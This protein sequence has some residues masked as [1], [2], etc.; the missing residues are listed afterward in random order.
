MNMFVQEL[1]AYRKSTIVW[2]ASVVTLMALMMLLF[3]AFME[4]TEQ[5]SLLLATIPSEVMQAFGLDIAVFLTVL[6]F[7]SYIFTY[8]V[9]SGAIQA[10][11]IGLSLFSKEIRDKT[12]EFLFVKP[13]TRTRI[14]IAKVS[15]ALMSLV[16]TSSI[17]LVLSSV[18]VVAVANEAVALS[19]LLLLSVTL[20]FVQ[21]I[22]LVLGLALSFV[23]PKIKSVLPL[24]LGVTFGLFSIGLFSAAIEDDAFRYVTPFKYFDAPY[25]ITHSRYEL[26]FVFISIAIVVVLLIVSYVLLQRKD[27]TI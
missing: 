8:V 3:P 1:R 15:A 17:Y 11:N 23:V 25:I 5:L 20:L 7:Y 4:D 16:I 27:I 21:M 12:A 9:L 2:T 22:F 19:T 10:M 18:V 14:F 6:G 26:P 13:V 24:S